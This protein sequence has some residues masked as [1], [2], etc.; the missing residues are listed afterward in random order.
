MKTTSKILIVTMLALATAGS[1]LSEPRSGNYGNPGVL[2]PHANY[3]GFSYSQWEAK[4]WQAL[5]AIPV[6]DGYH[7]FF[8]GGVFGGENGV[9][10]LTGVGGPTT[11]EITIPAGTALF[12]PVLNTECSVAETDPFHGDTE[13]ELRACANGFIDDTSGRFA[14]IDGVPVKNRD[15]YRVQSPL[16]EYGPLPE[17]NA[18]GLPAGTVSP[19]VDAG[20]YLLLAPLSVGEH[21]IHF[22]GTFD[23]LEFTV[24]TTYKIKVVPGKP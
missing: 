6:V 20:Y 14:E 9:M 3:R 5:L 22:R 2:P 8:S 19:S 17:D 1:A 16:F 18:F 10:F 15:A 13:T 12:F 24:D 11:V 4:W 21:M 7:P 23:G